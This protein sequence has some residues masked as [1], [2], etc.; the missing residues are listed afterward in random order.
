MAATVYAAPADL[1][2]WLGTAAPGNALPLL[3]SA[4]LV[5]AEAC[6]RNPYGDVPAAGD[7]QP[8]NDATC[9]QAASWISLGINPDAQ[10]ADGEAPVKSSS[11]LGNEVTYDTSGV[12]KGRS[13][14]ATELC[15]TAETILTAAGL[16]WV[17]LPVADTSGFLRDYGLG[18]RWGLYEAPLAESP[19]SC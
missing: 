9:A 16:L 8:L 4:S 3:R 15:A 14:A 18:P 13:L 7:V 5:V 10:G 2:K 12:V 1:A 17:P 19:W 6:D 11:M